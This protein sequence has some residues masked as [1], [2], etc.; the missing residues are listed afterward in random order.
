MLDH[1]LRDAEHEVIAAQG[2]WRAP[3]RGRHTGRAGQPVAARAGV[4]EMHQPH[5]TLNVL[6]GPTAS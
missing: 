4:M 6:E 5:L 1:L 2:P 3:A